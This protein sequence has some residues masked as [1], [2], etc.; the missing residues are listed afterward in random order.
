MIFFVVYFHQSVLHKAYHIVDKF[1]S[2]YASTRAKD[3]ITSDE[4]SKRSVKNCHK[5]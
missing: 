5:K 2:M 3:L 4:E 1:Q